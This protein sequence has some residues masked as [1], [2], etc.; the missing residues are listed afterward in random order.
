LQFLVHP[1]TRQFPRD[2]FCNPGPEHV[3]GKNTIGVG[4]H[5]DNMWL[6]YH[7]EV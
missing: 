1:S 5:Q 7:F 6:R 3:S 4:L 2:I